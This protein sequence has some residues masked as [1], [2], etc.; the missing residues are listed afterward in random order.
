MDLDFE[1]LIQISDVN[2]WKA[3]YHRLIQNLDELFQE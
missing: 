3:T 2:E 1:R